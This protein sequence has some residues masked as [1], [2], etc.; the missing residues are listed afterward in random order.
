MQMNQTSPSESKRRGERTLAIPKKRST[1]MGM[2][3]PMS[4]ETRRNWL[5]DAALFVGAVLAIL[6]G[7]YY[8]FLP[9]GGYQGGRNPMYGITILFDRRTWDDLHTWGGVAMIA[10]AVVHFALHWSWVVNTARRMWKAATGKGALMN[11]RGYFNVVID[12][13]IA[14]S[15]A[16]VAISGIYF[17]FVPGG[18]WATDPMLLF[19]RTTW[20]LIHTWAGV[21]L[22]VAAVAHFAIHWK[23]VVKV[24]RNTILSTWGGLQGLLNKPAAQPVRASGGSISE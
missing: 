1:I 2:T 15:F 4:K 18:R 16:L 14:V 22:V 6:T 9:S 17:L 24:T 13:V 11:R 5:I 7:I 3:K 21:M 8:L 10:A 20:D 19:S 12:L 23:W